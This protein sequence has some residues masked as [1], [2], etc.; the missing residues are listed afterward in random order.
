M[1]S[2]PY[3]DVPSLFRAMTPEERAYMQNIVD[4]LYARFVGIVADGRGMKEVDV[5]KFADG[6]VFLA[7]EAKK[8]GLIDD[9]GHRDMAIA[10]ARR[11]AG[12]S[13]AA[14]MIYRRKISPLEALLQ[15]GANSGP[16]PREAQ[17]MARMALHPRMLFLWR[18]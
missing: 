18:P 16:L 12:S 8:L 2:G 3:K 15:G 10:E 11:L 4:K 7:D 9:I 13:D 17:T 5:R 1:I 6:R 14:V